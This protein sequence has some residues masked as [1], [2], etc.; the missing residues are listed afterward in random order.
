MLRRKNQKRAAVTVPQNSTYISIVGSVLYKRFVGERVATTISENID[1]NDVG[2][3]RNGNQDR[4]E[5]RT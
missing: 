3:G 4:R 5:I 2:S 1:K